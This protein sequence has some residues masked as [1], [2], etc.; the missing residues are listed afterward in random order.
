MWQTL[1][2]KVHRSAAELVYL[3]RVLRLVWG[4][5]GR[6]TLLWMA[7]L[8][9]Q[10]VLPAVIML[11]TRELVD[12]LASLVGSGQS[13]TALLVQWQ[14]VA[15]LAG[16]WLLQEGLRGVNRWLQTLQGQYVYDAITAQIHLKSAEVDIA[17]YDSADFYNHLHRARSEA[18]YRPIELIG[19]LGSLL[20]NSITLL[21]LLGT[22]LAYAWWLPIA[23]L[24]SGLPALLIAVRFSIQLHQWRLKMSETERQSWYLDN[25]LTDYQ[26][27]PEIRLFT[28]SQFLRDSYASLRQVLRDGAIRLARQQMVAEWL[29]IGSGL[30]A[31]GGSLLWA[32]AAL[33]RGTISLGSVTLF[34]QAF[35]YGNRVTSQLFNDINQ[36]YYNTLLLSDLFAFL[37]LEPLVLDSADCL[38]TPKL[39]SAIRFENITFTYPGSQHA[40]LNQFSHTIKAGSLVALVG[41]NGEGKSTLL[42]LLCRFYDPT[43]GCIRIDGVDLRDMAR[44]AWWRE[45]TVLW[46]EPMRYSMTVK[47]NISIGRKAQHLDWQIQAVA[48]AAG[49]A[50]FIADLPHSYDTLLGRWF[51]G[52]QELSVGQW[53]RLALA[54]SYFRET[55]LL[56]LDE[57]TSAL[58]AWAEADWISR[59]KKNRSGRTTLLITHRLTTAMHADQIVIMHEGKVAEC[60]THSQLLAL[61]GRYATAWRGLHRD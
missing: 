56:L 9:L 44:Q 15:L 2:S 49:A 21:T 45:V 33:L 61:N 57:P 11:A 30:L 20:Q 16:S 14:P 59:L 40:V 52:G 6:W 32:V 18:G 58:D 26:S 13:L 37:D 36:I 43:E 12:G 7:L 4:A 22:L 1:K 51:K 3:P 47:D 34:Y 53:Q 42:K 38:P 10:G 17:F 23:L 54:R 50:D 25:L 19:N 24:L 55:P 29:A 46:Q 35:S 41:E 48:D 39:C 31:T 60:G 5:A 8:V 28:L 27:A